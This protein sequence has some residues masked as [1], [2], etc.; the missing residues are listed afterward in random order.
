[1]P[2]GDPPQVRR[3]A[4]GCGLAAALAV[5]CILVLL[6]TGGLCPPG[7]LPVE[8]APQQ[9]GYSFTG[10]TFLAAAWLAWRRMR[11]TSPAGSRDDTAQ[12]AAY[13]GE[14]RTVLLVSA[15]TALWGCLYWHMVGWHGARHALTFLVLTPAMYLCFAPRP[16]RRASRQEVP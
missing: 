2:A 7:R 3:R 5:P 6:A 14:I 16:Y 1:M 13:R 9:L 12:V 11:G 15:S 8:G 4:W 10:L